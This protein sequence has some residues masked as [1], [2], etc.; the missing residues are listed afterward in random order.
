MCAVSYEELNKDRKPST[1]LLQKL[2]EVADLNMNRARIE[3]SNMWKEMKDHISTVG[4]HFNEGISMYAIDSLRQLAKKFLEKEEL[5]N[6][7]FQKDFLEP[8]NIIM[9]NNMPARMNIIQFIM[10]CM[11]LF[12]VQKT[13][14]LKSGWEIIIEIF[15]FGGENE[16]YELS[17]EAIDTLTVVLS[18]KNFQ[19]VEEYFEKVVNCLFKFVNNKFQDHSLMALDL[20]EKVAD[21]LGENP[22]LIDRIIDK[23]RMMFGSKQEREEYKK[24]LWKSI[25]YELSKKAFEIKNDVTKRAHSLMINLLSRHN[26]N[27]SNKL[28]KMLFS[29]LLKAMFDDLH[30]KMESKSTDAEMHQI[31]LNNTSVIM[32]DLI[33][34]IKSMEQDKF[35]ASVNILLDTIL[36]FALSYQ[37]SPVS[38]VMIESMRV[39]TTDCGDMFTQSLWKSFISIICQLYENKEDK[40]LLSDQKAIDEQETK[41]GNHSKLSTLYQTQASLLLKLIEN[42]DDIAKKYNELDSEDILHLLKNLETNYDLIHKFNLNI[43]RRFELYEKIDLRTAHDKVPILLRHEINILEV[44]FIFLNELYNQNSEGISKE[45]VVMKIIEFSTKVLSDFAANYDKTFH[46]VAK[47]KG[48]PSK[49]EKYGN[50]DLLEVVEEMKRILVSTSA[51]ISHSVLRTLLHLQKED[52]KAHLTELSPLL[53]DCTV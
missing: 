26:S 13:S 6:Y 12:A 9:L 48:S 16:N 37:N 20:I 47:S 32:Y 51:A 41:F 34:L 14:N 44:Y 46:L 1:F 2:V 4:S 38:I 35:E 40:S 49:N 45:D 27:M 15:K 18:Q 19:Y 29:D 11:C 25:F 5:N 39:L 28:W 8:F 36:N 53:I 10:S 30:I 42:T 33:S 23:G 52:L 7:H 22:G 24:A 17:K 43:E 3:F 31:Y 21:N 50:L